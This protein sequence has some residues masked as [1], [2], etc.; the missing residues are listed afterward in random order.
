MKQASQKK[1]ISGWSR[2]D[3]NYGSLDFQDQCQDHSATLPPSKFYENEMFWF[4]LQFTRYLR[5]VPSESLSSRYKEYDN[6]EISQTGA[7][8][9]APKDRCFHI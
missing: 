2:R 9:Q 3:L 8:R 7:K 5:A 6:S 1:N 4:N